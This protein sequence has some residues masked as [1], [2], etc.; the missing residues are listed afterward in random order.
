MRL[1]VCL[2]LFSGWLCACSTTSGGSAGPEEPSPARPAW[3]GPIADRYYN[4]ST[5]AT[6]SLR[7]L[8][9]T[10][11][12]VYLTRTPSTGT[13]A[14]ASY[15]I[16]VFEDGTFVYEGHRCV[17]VGGVLVTRI[18]ADALARLEKTL[19]ATCVDLAG[20]NDG[21]LCGD[22]ATLRVRCA[23]GS[24]VES[25]SDHCRKSEPA[26]RRLASLHADLVESL[27]LEM[28][29]GQPSERQACAYGARD[30]APHELARIVYAAER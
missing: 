5:P 2:A 1:I 12:L 20:L 13:F 24:S 15:E 29:V 16:A 14:E 28:F 27:G 30:L 17:R 11:P 10:P 23:V 6:P 9:G 26:G 25:G 18:G 3:E 21:E 8:K 19:A 22:E 7:P 4:A